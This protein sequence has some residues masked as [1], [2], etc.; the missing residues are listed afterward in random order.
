MSHTEH[1]NNTP[2]EMPRKIFQSVVQQPIEVK[3][4]LKNKAG[5]RTLKK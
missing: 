1:P 2:P 5:T 3:Q 4:L